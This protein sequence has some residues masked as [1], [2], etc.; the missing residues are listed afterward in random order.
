M[1]LVKAVQDL[2]GARSLDEVVSTLRATT[3][4]VVGA[5]GIAIVVRDGNHS[6][7]VAE[8]AVGALWLGQRFPLAD[9]ISGQAMIDDRLIAIPDIHADPRV[10]H[11]AYAGTFVKSMA[12][13]PIG[14]K[15]P[16]AALCAYWAKTGPVPEEALQSLK[17]LAGAA[18]TAIEN[19]RLFEALVAS[20]RRFR[21]LFEASPAGIAIYDVPGHAI[22]DVNDTMLRL[23]GMTRREFETGAWDFVRATPP[24]Q[25]ARDDLSREQIRRTGRNRPYEKTYV[26]RDGTRVPVLISAAP[27]DDESGA[28]I[29]VT[30]EL[31]AVKAAEAALA[32]SEALL[33]GITETVREAFYT[34]E[35]SQGGTPSVAYISAAFE[36]IWGRS[37]ESLV[38]DPMSF[39]DAVHPEDRPR[40]EA[41]VARQLEG[42]ET[43]TEY[44]ITDPSGAEKWIYDCAYPVL[45]EDGRTVRVIGVADDITARKR[46]E[47]RAE[48]IAREMDHRARNLMTIVRGIVGQ[49]L[50]SQDVAPAVAEVLLGRLAALS[51]AHKAIMRQNYTSASMGELVGLAL[52]PFSA[53]AARIAA[54]GP[55]C[56]LAPQIGLI[57]ALALHELATNAMKHGALSVP[58]GA[59]TLGW[60]RITIGD[61]HAFRMTWCERGGPLV[62]AA[63]PKA[64]G[65]GTNLLEQGLTWYGGETRLDFAPEGLTAIL[66]LPLS[67]NPQD[68]PEGEDAE[69]AAA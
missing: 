17:T 9:C 69:R 32:Q 15:R 52:E 49:T 8:D 46:T 44:R 60:E 1:L 51:A 27:L 4:A 67:L 10:P 40:V 18:A 33:R 28:T 19:A 24:D 62:P 38:A 29:V 55:D 48:L 14:A 35:F 59:V 2:A 30:Q 21:N 57:L 50:R 12:A 54:E 53:R 36:D 41:A 34:M 39:L 31:T 20:E 65:F 63:R 61:Q 64:S 6:H 22:V 37:R 56:A 42:E 26:H 68:G 11:A 5:D 43:A 23:A 25:L 66:S 47:M 7:Y 45:G 13:V 16:S 58:T 3:R